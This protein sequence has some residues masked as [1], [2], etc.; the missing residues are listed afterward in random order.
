[1]E[2]S[3]SLISNPNQIQIL[4]NPIASTVTVFHSPN[5]GLITFKLTQRLKD[6]QSLISVNLD[7]RICKVWSNG[8]LVFRLRRNQQQVIKNPVDLFDS[9]GCNAQEFSLEQSVPSVT[10]D[11]SSQL[12]IDSSLPTK[13]HTVHLKGRRILN[14]DDFDIVKITVE[15]CGAETISSKHAS[16]VLQFLEKKPGESKQL[17]DFG[18]DFSVDSEFCPIGFDLV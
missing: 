1:M 14:H 12:K 8:D 13:T 10:L 3:I 9:S 7:V 17:F 11:T 6:G 4:I 18:A 16:R 5:L 15:I 2:T